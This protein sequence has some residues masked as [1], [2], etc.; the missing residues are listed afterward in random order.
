MPSL[1]HF[2]EF[3]LDPLSGELRRKGSRVKLQNQPLQVLLSLLEHPGDVVTREEL[4]QRLWP[5]DTFVDFDRGLNKAI[6]MLR[7]ALHDRA[8]RPRFVETFPR[9]GYRFLVPAEAAPHTTSQS[10][11]DSSQSP[12]GS[13]IEAL[14]VLP[15]E[16]LSGDPAEEYFSDGMTAELISALASI[17]SLRVISRTSALTYRGTRK[18]MPVI[19]RE[20]HVD[21]VVEGSV[22]RAD[23]RVRISAQLIHAREDRLLWSGRYERDLQDVLQLQ[24][25]IASA[26]AAQI[27]T[28][29][30]P[31]RAGRLLARRIEPRAYEAWLRGS[32]FRETLSPENLEK[33]IACF[34]EAIGL[35]PT[36]AQAHGDLAQCYFYRVIF[37]IGD[38]TTMFAKARACAMSALE[39]DPTIATAHIALSAIHV[40]HDW[41]WARAEA[42]CR[43]AVDVSPGDP[44]CRSHLSDIM[45]IRGRHDEA[46][47]ESHRVLQL[48]P[49]STVF[50]SFSG[51]LYYR[52]RRYDESIV[53]C[54]R[55]LEIDPT[56][57]NARWFMALS[58]EQ[59]GE[60]AEAIA[61]LEETVAVSR[62]PHFRALLAR[63][64]GLAGEPA[65]ARAILS[66][67]IA[68][69]SQWYVSPFDIAVIHAGLGDATSAF[70][71]LEEAYQQRVWRIIELTLPMFDSLRA[72]DRWHE[73]VRRIGLPH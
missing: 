38:A 70:Q 9:R 10:S 8:T 57:V 58:L 18:Q 43:K 36:Y 41:D 33:S 40:F 73:L 26:I 29:V 65:K 49:L 60:I 46:I 6:N 21:A 52:A 71:W 12:D 39:L 56:F 19:A 44:R 14:A 1:I 59:K 28:F 3:A 23:H 42:V 62:A 30:D 51:L 63:A 53:E 22:A 72:D 31:D 5:A 11:G 67:L 17:G 48:D 68:L 47:A 32:F 24:V 20:L 13:R 34:S 7:R 15:L 45:S 64:Y 27:K 37:G 69:S 50:R 2:G 16:N 25:E 4:R 35:D 54:R 66:D 61:T 55:A